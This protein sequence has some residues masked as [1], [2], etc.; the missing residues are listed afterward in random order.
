M[1]GYHP[2]FGVGDPFEEILD[3]PLGLMT[4]KL[5]W[6]LLVWI[7]QQWWIQDFSEGGANPKRG[8][9]G[10]QLIISSNFVENCMKMTKFELLLCTSAIVQCGRI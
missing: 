1:I 5:C 3:P 7:I 6:V 10:C 8:V 4:G 9:G 2:P